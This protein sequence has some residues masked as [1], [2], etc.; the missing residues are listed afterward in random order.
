MIPARP[1]FHLLYER[2]IVRPS[3]DA[4]H[5]SRLHKMPRTRREPHETLAP[6]R[7]GILNHEGGGRSR[8]HLAH[9]T[10][11]RR[12]FLLQQQNALRRQI[13]PFGRVEN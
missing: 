9:G 5:T 12:H 1:Y 7:V 13:K 4:E 6:W 8:P 3:S 2:F 10:E 11:I